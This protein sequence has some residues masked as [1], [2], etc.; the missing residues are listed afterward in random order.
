MA[1]LDLFYLLAFYTSL[2]LVIVYIPRQS[3]KSEATLDK[4]AEKIG[5]GYAKWAAK[6]NR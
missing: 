6:Q 1:V 5:K 4:R 3:I 2:V